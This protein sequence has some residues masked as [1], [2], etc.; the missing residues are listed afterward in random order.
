MNEFWRYARNVYVSDACKNKNKMEP[1]NHEATENAIIT[2]HDDHDGSNVDSRHP[3]I[4]A[5]AHPSSPAY[6]ESSVA[7][8]DTVYDPS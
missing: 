4:P 2:Y 1:Q 5:V 8:L 6:T 3:R 7:P